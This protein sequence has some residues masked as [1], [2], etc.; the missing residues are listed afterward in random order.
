MK[1]SLGSSEEEPF[2]QQSCHFEAEL[3]K[4]EEE[5][6]DVLMQLLIKGQREKQETEKA[7]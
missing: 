3:K 5:E 1:V 7:K 6:E 4:E 2:N